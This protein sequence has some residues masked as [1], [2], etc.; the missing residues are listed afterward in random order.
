MMTRKNQVDDLLARFERKPINQKTCPYCHHGEQRFIKPLIRHTGE[1][2]DMGEMDYHE[3]ALDIEHNQLY[4][5]GYVLN[6]GEYCFETDANYCP[7]CG[8]KFAK[9]E[10][11]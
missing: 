8:R 10:R 6:L 5:Q 3:A 7:K 2:G 1:T 4:I 11:N 9:N